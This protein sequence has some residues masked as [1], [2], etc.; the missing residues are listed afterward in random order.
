M[1]ITLNRKWRIG[2]WTQIAGA[3][4]G[5]AASAAADSMK[6]ANVPY[7]GENVV[8]GVQPGFM[9]L[10]KEK[11]GTSTNLDAIGTGL[12]NLNERGGRQAPMPG[13]ADSDWLR[14]LMGS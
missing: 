2:G 13:A 10:L 12:Y 5:A 7:S 3:L 1:K 11:T 4:V 8:S 6:K 9:D 14:L